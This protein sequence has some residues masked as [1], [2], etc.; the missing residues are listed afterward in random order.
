MPVGS[1]HPIAVTECTT[2]LSASSPHPVSDLCPLQ[3]VPNTEARVIPSE[4]KVDQIARLLEA[5]Q[6]FFVTAKQNPVCLQWY[7]CKTLVILFPPD[8]PPTVFSLFSFSTQFFSFLS[9]L[10]PH[11]PPFWS[12]KK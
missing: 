6:W 7:T 8:P 3:C 11:W 1:H 2:V 9:L 12:L 5:L 4:H 10:N